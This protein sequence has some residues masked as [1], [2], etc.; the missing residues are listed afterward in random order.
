MILFGRLVGVLCQG[1]S[2]GGVGEGGSWVA[3]RW[4]V[5]FGWVRGGFGEVVR[6]LLCEEVVVGV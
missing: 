3:F 5:A 4:Q 1:E 2:G 6:G